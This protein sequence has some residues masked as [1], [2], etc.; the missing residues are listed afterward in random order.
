MACESCK[1][2]GKPLQVHHLFYDPDREPWDYQIDEVVLLCS[3]CHEQLHG[4][5]ARFR[6]YVFRKLTPAAFRVVNGALAAGLDAHDPLKF[7]YAVASMAASPG[8]VER[9]A[10]D[11]KPAQQKAE[12]PT[13]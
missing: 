3:T 11:W 1:Q 6:R 2:G 4:E 5:L 13:P 7:A 8:S 12:N 9:F 10:A